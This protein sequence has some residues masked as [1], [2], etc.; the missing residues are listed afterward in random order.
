MVCTLRPE[1]KEG[2]ALGTR[3]EDSLKAVEGHTRAGIYSAA[4]GGDNTGT[5][6]YF[7]KEVLPT[8][9]PGRADKNCEEEAMAERSSYGLSVT[10]ILTATQNGKGR[11]IE[12]EGGRMTL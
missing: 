1:K 11:E 6:G 3:A 9:H 8:E 5:F 2:G 4:G 12:N 7:L 10:P